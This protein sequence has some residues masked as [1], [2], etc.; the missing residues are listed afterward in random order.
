[1]MADTKTTLKPCPFAVGDIVYVLGKYMVSAAAPLCIVR[2]QISHIY[3]RQFVAYGLDAYSEWRF[4]AKHY[5]KSV[6]KSEAEAIEA[7]NRRANDG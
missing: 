1:M 4:S 3:R 5:N 7:W 2:A 6:F